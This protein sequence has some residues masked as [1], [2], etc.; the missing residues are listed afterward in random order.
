MGMKMVSVYKSDVVEI[1]AG[2]EFEKDRDD[3]HLLFF[4]II[5]SPGYGEGWVCRVGIAG[6]FCYVLCKDDR[7]TKDDVIYN[8]IKELGRCKIIQSIQNSIPIECFIYDDNNGKDEFLAVL[9]CTIC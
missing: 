3:S 5:P 6:L 4:R 2:E 7:V 1:L 9:E 8:V